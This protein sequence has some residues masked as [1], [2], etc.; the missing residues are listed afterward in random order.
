[1][2]KQIDITG[3]QYGRWM[4]LGE[5]KNK[6]GHWMCQCEC[7]TVKS[8]DGNSLRRGGTLS[9]G[10]LARELAKDRLTQDLTGKTFGDWTVL[11][12]PVHQSGKRTKWH[13]RCK[14]GIERDVYAVNLTRGMTTSCGCESGKK[15][16]ESRKTHGK[17]NTRLYTVWYDMRR[18]CLDDKNTAYKHYG[19]RGIKIC[20][21]W[22]GE[23]GFQHFWDWA[24]ANGYDDTA[25]IAECTLDRIDVNGNYEP[26]NCRW[27]DAKTQGRNRTDTTYL[28]IGDTTRSLGDWS[29]QYN[30]SSVLVRARIKRGW[31]AERALTEPPKKMYAEV[32]Y[33]GE[34]HS[35]SEWARIIGIKKKT[36]QYRVEHGWSVEELM[37][38]IG[39]TNH[40][41]ESQNDNAR[42]I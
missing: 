36:M 15:I 13:C 6:K 27:V 7:G 10:C 42:K 41:K 38:P 2:A 22:L 25:K 23:N 34:V 11:Y 33:N 28:T 21:E 14:C 9:C 12:G 8:V 5:D 29:E 20:D 39:T 35:Y 1:M 26:S 18:R 16:G 30:T 24:Y 37:S 31:D 4:V 32:E 19:G 3:N 17:R 40:R